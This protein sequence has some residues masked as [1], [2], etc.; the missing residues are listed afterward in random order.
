MSDNTRPHPSVAPVVAPVCV[1]GFASAVSLAFV[2]GV[3]A[4]VLFGWAAG[5]LVVFATPAIMQLLDHRPPVR[6][7]YNASAFALTAG[8]AGWAIGPVQGHQPA[9]TA[10]RVA[11]AV[12]V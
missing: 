1:A 5:A 8:A 6:I 4:I 2:F 7:A 9:E 3:S 11:V 12:Y 10:A